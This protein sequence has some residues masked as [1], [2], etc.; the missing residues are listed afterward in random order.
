MGS[1]LFFNLIAMHQVK[2]TIYKVKKK[3]I[4]ANVKV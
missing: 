3:N 2:E 4:K 1:F